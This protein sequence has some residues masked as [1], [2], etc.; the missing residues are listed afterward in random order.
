M[1]LDFLFFT[2]HEVGRERRDR[3]GAAT[4]DGFGDDRGSG[5]EGV[6]TAVVVAGD[7]GASLGAGASL[8]W[9][10]ERGRRDIGSR[11]MFVLLLVMMSGCWHYLFVF[12]YGFFFFFFFSWFVEIKQRYNTFQEF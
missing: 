9:G 11:R 7:D 8:N 2:F 1:A 10:I 4:A 5:V 3:E 6:D 12:L